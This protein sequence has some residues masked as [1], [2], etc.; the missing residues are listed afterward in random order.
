MCA[1]ARCSLCKEEASK[2]ADVPEEKWKDTDKF[3]PKYNI[4]PGSNA[5]VVVKDGEART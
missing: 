3:E 4:Q 2:K 1:R 5:L